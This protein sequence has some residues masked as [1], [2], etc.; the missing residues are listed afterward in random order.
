MRVSNVILGSRLKPDTDPAVE[1]VWRV[2]Q[3]MDDFFHSLFRLS[4]SL[5]LS[6]LETF[7]ALVHLYYWSFLV[8]MAVEDFLL[9]VDNIIE[10]QATMNNRGH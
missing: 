5:Y 3:Q 8:V 6:I 1:A 9:M 10:R 7:H 2:N 4:F